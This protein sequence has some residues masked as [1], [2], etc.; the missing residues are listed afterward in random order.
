MYIS[1]L[2]EYIVVNYIRLPTLDDP[3]NP[4]LSDPVVDTDGVYVY[5]TELL[6]LGLGFT[7]LTLLE[8][9]PRAFKPQELCK[10]S[11]QPSG[12]ISLH[13][14]ESQRT[15][16]LWSRCINTRGTNIPCDLHMEHLNRR[17]K[18]V[19]KGMDLCTPTI[20]T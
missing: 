7:M 6:M 13:A 9:F 16:F 20:S 12:A 1:E 15:Q 14:S 2:A 4:T 8:D 10:R 18:S 19:L 3:P 11:S 5:A 17:F